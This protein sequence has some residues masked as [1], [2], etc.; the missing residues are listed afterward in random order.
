M[1]IDEDNLRYYNTSAGKWLLETG[2]YEI[3]I[4][5]DCQN[6]K[7]YGKVM[8]KGDEN[9]PLYS[10]DVVSAYEKDIAGISD[11]VFEKVLGC[12]IPPLLPK[13]PITLESTF[14]DLKVSFMGRIFFNAVMSV[15][16][17]Q[18]RQAEKLP[19]GLEKDNRI[20]GALF[21]SR[22]LESNSLRSMSM[23]A[24]K[25][26]PYNFAL[27][28]ME[29]ANGHIIKGIKHFLT[30]IEAPELPKEREDA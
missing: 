4:C 5:S 14:S 8:I 19:E 10:E 7:L 21:L 23:S 17:K 25:S 11:D 9:I 18:R 15:A 2:Q 26:F 13:K 12:K 30:K 24:R 6:I 27:G 1:V 16:N 3:Q 22:I 20:K 29:M 28:F